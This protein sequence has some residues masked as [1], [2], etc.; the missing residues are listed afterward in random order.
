M[1]GAQLAL[2][3]LVFDNVLDGG[4][5]QLSR[6]LEFGLALRVYNLFF[7]QLLYVPEIA[8][9]VLKLLFVKLVICYESQILNVHRVRVK[10]GDA[11]EVNRYILV[12]ELRVFN[13]DLS[14]SVCLLKL[15]ERLIKGALAILQRPGI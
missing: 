14:R 12:T 2:A 8:G 13:F 10:L 11:A 3:T 6:L 7:L 9:D 4:C 15:L 1:V 5:L